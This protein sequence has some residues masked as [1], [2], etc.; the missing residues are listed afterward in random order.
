MKKSKFTKG[1]I[2]FAQCQEASCLDWVIND[3]ALRT[4]N[5]L[6]VFRIDRLLPDE[7]EYMPKY[8]FAS[9]HPINPLGA[10]FR[11]LLCDF[12]RTKTA[13]LRGEIGQK[14]R[15]AEGQKGFVSSDKSLI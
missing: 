10:S 3:L 14:G 1:Q 13:S 6:M 5:L 7:M 12:A 11:A 2:V 8:K 4:L 9:F 15:R